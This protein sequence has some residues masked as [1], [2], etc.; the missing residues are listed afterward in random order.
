MITSMLQ[1]VAKGIAQGDLD[2]YTKE[3]IQRESNAAEKVLHGTYQLKNFK[4]DGGRKKIDLP[5]QKNLLTNYSCFASLEAKR[6]FIAPRI[7]PSESNETS[8][9]C[10]NVNEVKHGSGTDDSNF[11]GGQDHGA[12]NESEVL[13]FTEIKS[14]TLLQNPVCKPCTSLD[15]DCDSDRKKR[16]ATSINENGIVRSTYFLKKSRE[17]NKIDMD[18]KGD[19]KLEKVVSSNACKPLSALLE[20]KCGNNEK[21]VAVQSSYFQQNIGKNSNCDKENVFGKFSF[22]TR[23]FD[24]DA[25]DSKTTINN[26]K[27]R[28]MSSYFEESSVNENNEVRV[29][30]DFVVRNVADE[31]CNYSILESPSSTNS[32][33]HT[34]KRRKIV[35]TDTTPIG[36]ANDNRTSDLSGTSTSIIEKETKA[37][38]G[39]F[40]CNISHLGRYS[41]IAEKSMGKFVSV[42]SSFKYKSSGSRAS[43]L[44]APLKDVNNSMQSSRV[45]MDL[46]NF[47]YT[48]TK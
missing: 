10:I 25:S 35:Q 37:E 1:H 38:E 33:G 36:N 4:P 32:L 8:S 22:Q 20:G 7:I 46:G 41:D 6:K 44:R 17:E 48:P 45:S 43:G 15:K 31:P 11:L 2:P 42:I 40:G 19:H 21:T 34:P 16:K 47:A 39:K 14:L 24:L 26:R 3:P 12:S 18:N 23:K 13:G 28:L 30:E 29:S 9:P 5:V 27:N